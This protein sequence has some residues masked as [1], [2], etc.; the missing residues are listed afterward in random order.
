MPRGVA[1]EL[2]KVGGPTSA[3]SLVAVRADRASN[4]G[5][6]GQTCYCEVPTRAR[7]SSFPSAVVP[8]GG[9]GGSRSS[10]LPL[11]LRGNWIEKLRVSLKVRA[12]RGHDL[13]LCIVRSGAENVRL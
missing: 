9:R 4:D 11:C 3:R 8:P 10:M 12:H 1:E 6:S 7:G 5:C 13:V 2:T